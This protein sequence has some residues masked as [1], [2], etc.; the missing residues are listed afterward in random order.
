MILAG[1]FAQHYPADGVIAYGGLLGLVATL[2]I[3]VRNGT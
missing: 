1:G 3:T 2:L